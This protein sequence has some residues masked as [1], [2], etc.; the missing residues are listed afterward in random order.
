MRALIILLASGLY[1]GYSP[2]APGTAG[3]V[4]GLVLVYFVTGPMWTHSPAKCLAIFA[5]V[6]AISCWIA[7]RAEKIFDEHDSPKIVL[8]EVLG[9]AVTMFGNPLTA[10]W[11]IVGFVLFRISDVIKPWPASFFDRQLQNGAGVM[12]DDLASAVYANIA[13]QVLWRIL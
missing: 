13:L 5:I 8:D 7:D 4:V 11:L 10:A 1:S 6:F 9:M 3:S 12:L 2:V